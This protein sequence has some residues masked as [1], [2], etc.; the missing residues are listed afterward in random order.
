MRAAAAGTLTQGPRGL[1]PI[2]T[3]HRQ[4]VLLSP[5]CHLSARS[6]RPTFSSPSRTGSTTPLATSTRGSALTI[7]GDVCDYAHVIGLAD[8][9]SAPSTRDDPDH[10][11]RRA[12]GPVRPCRPGH[13]S[14]AV[15]D[16]FTVSFSKDMAAAR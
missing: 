3:E 5:F 7:A 16:R 9:A 4:Q 1:L 10:R 13:Q 15:I 14:S 11:R 12:S 2:D 6:T 8:Q